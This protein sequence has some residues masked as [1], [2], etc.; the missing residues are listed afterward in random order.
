MISGNDTSNRRD[1]RGRGISTD[2]SAM[3]RFGER[4]LASLAEPRPRGVVRHRR[5]IPPA[6]FAFHAARALDGDARLGFAVRLDVGWHRP[7]LD[8]RYDE[9]HRQLLRVGLEV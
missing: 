7:Q 3:N 8:L 5:Y 4:P 1:G 2:D 6:A 9:Q